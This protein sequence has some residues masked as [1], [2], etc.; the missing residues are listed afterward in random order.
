M[1]PLGPINEKHSQPDFPSDCE[2]KVTPSP[3][4]KLPICSSTTAS[5][6]VVLH[7]IPLSLSYLSILPT[8][9]MNLTNFFW[10]KAL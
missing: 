6:T 3:T 10:H 2:C 4:K 1:L 7:L 9:S 8:N 5:T